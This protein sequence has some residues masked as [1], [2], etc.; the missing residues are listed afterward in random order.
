MIEGA[1]D[2]IATVGE[3]S[4]ALLVEIYGDLAR[5]GVRQVGRALETVIQLGAL[6]LLPLRMANAYA[7]EWERRKYAEIA[8]RFS[9]IPED[10]IEPARPE[11][12]V[13]VL[14]AL[15]QTED[16]QL[17]KLFIEL[18]A[19][20]SNSKASH[21]CHPSFVHVIKHIAPQEAQILQLWS[22]AASVPFL[23]ISQR[24]NRISRR[25]LNQI[26]DLPDDFEN[27]S[28]IPV[29]L[30]N[31]RGLGILTQSTTR[32]LAEEAYEELIAHAQRDWPG[33][34]VSVVQA[35]NHKSEEGPIFYDKGV[36]EILAYGQLFQRACLA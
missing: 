16:G 29:Y 3:S 36:I 26:Y 18:L 27:P 20:A 6:A 8:D 32:W 11:I 9:D 22:G 28:L 34:T 15:N 2:V 19:N 35:D 1:K 5:P 14:E 24:V 25:Q 13:P 12:A 10:Q 33:I 23:E 17:R 7:A 4:K 21:L 30:S 31:L